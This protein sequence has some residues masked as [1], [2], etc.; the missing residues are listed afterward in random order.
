MHRAAG[1]STSSGDGGGKTSK[2]VKNG[3]LSVGSPAGGKA[4]LGGLTP[5]GKIQGPK[6]GKLTSLGRGPLSSASDS[7]GLSSSEMEAAKFKFDTYADEKDGTIHKS[8]LKLLLGEMDLNLSS[9]V[10]DN[11]VD[12]TYRRYAKT[13]GKGIA[14]TSFLEIYGKVIGDKK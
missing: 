4:K 14:W 12:M 8:G 10:F 1:F 6:G 7:A 5:L 9:D 11:Y 2:T 13:L 3:G